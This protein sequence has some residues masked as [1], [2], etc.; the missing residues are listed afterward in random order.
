MERLLL[1]LLF[2]EVSDLCEESFFL[3]RLWCRLGSLFL[4]SKIHELH[5]SLEHDEYN[6]SHDHEVDNIS[7]E[8][9]YVEVSIP[10]LEVDAVES[11][12]IEAADDRR[13]DVIQQ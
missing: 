4:L 9:T 13:N 2:K 7:D 12:D 8:C 3:R 1:I 5:N 11:A 10:D 6:K